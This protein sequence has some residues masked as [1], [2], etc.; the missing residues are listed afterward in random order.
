M[1]GILARIVA[2]SQADFAFML[3]KKRGACIMVGN[4]GAQGGGWHSVHSPLYASNDAILT[5]GAA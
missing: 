4:G 2:P 3:E 1:Q 5:T